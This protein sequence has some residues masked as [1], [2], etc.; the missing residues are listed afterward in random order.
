MCYLYQVSEA[1]RNI[2]HLSIQESMKLK[3]E[4]SQMQQVSTVAK[5]ELKEHVEKLGSRFLEDLFSTTEA[6]TIM[7]DCL[8]EW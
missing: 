3:Q 6:T 8:S 2:Q 1:S 4:M 5:K 7:E